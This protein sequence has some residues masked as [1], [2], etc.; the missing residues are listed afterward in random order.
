[1]LPVLGSIYWY[2]SYVQSTGSKPMQTFNFTV[3]YVKDIPTSVA[4]YTALFG[5]PP[6]DASP[7]FAMF[8]FDNKAMLG[9]WRSEHVIPP[10][11][12]PS[13]GSELAFVVPDKQAVDAAYAGWVEC[14]FTIG[15]APTER[16]F[17][18]SAIVLDPDGH[19]IRVMKPG[20]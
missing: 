8:A 11:T 16:E 14:G 4:F 1:M 5:R 6:A 20:G 19:R 15:L 12:A 7:A 3:F 2:C 10:A 13:G 9:L 18:Y 17:A